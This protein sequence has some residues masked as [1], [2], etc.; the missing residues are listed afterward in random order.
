MKKSVKLIALVL[1]FVMLTAVLVSCGGPSSDSAKAMENLKGNGYT[2]AKDST[3]IPTALN[4]A[5]KLAKIDA[6]ID[7]VITGVKTEKK[8]DTTTVDTVTVVYFADK[9]SANAAWDT[10]K[11]YAEE[12]KKDNEK[13]NFVIEK[14]G[15]MIYWGTKAGI[16]AA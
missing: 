15:A 3:V 16:K 4:V 12:N 13:D 7:T 11:K 6:T 14:S 8:D 10:V 1:T 5:L 2:A 9:D